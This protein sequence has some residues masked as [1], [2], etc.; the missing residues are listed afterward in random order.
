M[1]A[2]VY[3]GL[4][5]VCCAG[6]GRG[7]ALEDEDSLGGF[8]AEECAVESVESCA[9]D[10]FVVVSAHDSQS[11]RRSSSSGELR[12]ISLFSCSGT[13]TSILCFRKTYNAAGI[14]GIYQIG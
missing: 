5:D 1:I 3:A 13:K 14:K 4:I 7:V 12:K 9:D 6:E 8:C 11:I 2:H 10:D